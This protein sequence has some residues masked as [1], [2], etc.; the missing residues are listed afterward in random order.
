MQTNPG[1]HLDLLIVGKDLK[2]F[3]VYSGIKQMSKCVD[4]LI[5]GTGFSLW[6]KRRKYGMREGNSGSREGQTLEV[7]IGMNG[8]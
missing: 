7:L 3:Q 5:L 1:F 8:F 2:L 6:K 4:V